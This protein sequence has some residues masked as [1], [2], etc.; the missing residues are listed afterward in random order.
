[1]HFWNAMF[2]YSDNSNGTECWVWCHLEIIM[3]FKSNYSKF[4]ILGSHILKL[5]SLGDLYW[6]QQWRS[7]IFLSTASFCK[8]GVSAIWQS[9]PSHPAVSLS[10]CQ[11]TCYFVH[12]FAT[13]TCNHIVASH[14]GG[15]SCIK[16]ADRRNSNS[17]H[18]T[19]R[20]GAPAFP[21]APLLTV[22]TNWGLCVGVI[23]HFVRRL[24]IY[25]SAAPI[26]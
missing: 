4:R 13:R 9:F 12:E 24:Q 21:P 14:S 6:L 8:T 20:I 7:L 5:A 23:I 18:G 26:V 25:P 19:V 2:A 10:Y 3:P 16:S 22:K 1:M 11:T 17:D 15:S